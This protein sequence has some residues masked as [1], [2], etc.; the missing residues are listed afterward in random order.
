MM[1]FIIGKWGPGVCVKI[2]TNDVC[3]NIT[4]IL[5]NYHVHSLLYMDTEGEMKKGFCERERSNLKMW[6][7]QTVLMILSLSVFLCAE[8]S[9][10][11]LGSKR[12]SWTV[13]LLLIMT[14]DPLVGLVT[15]R[16]RREIVTWSAP[17]PNN[18]RRV[19]PQTF[20]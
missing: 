1:E 2:Y 10:N 20:T 15:C 9:N 14:V 5:L 11:H 17:S 3:R 18:T 8:T 4:T 16:L 12:L 19:R 7:R 13:I 6:I